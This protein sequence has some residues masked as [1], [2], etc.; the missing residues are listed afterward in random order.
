LGAFSIAC[1]RC[2]PESESSKQKKDDEEEEEEEEGMNAEEAGSESSDGKFFSLASKAMKKMEV[3][4]SISHEP[5][6]SLNKVFKSPKTKNPLQCLV[7]QPKL[8]PV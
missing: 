8:Q 7:R 5:Q 1:R 3:R 4:W 2:F 6:S